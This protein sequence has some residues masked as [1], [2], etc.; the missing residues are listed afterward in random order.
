[1]FADALE[2]MV[3]VKEY[4]QFPVTVEVVTMPPLVQFAGVF[5]A[6]ELFWETRN[7]LLV[8]VKPPVTVY[9]TPW[10]AC[11]VCELTATEAAKET[12]DAR[13]IIRMGIRIFSGIDFRIDLV[14]LIS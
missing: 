10:T 8:A 5:D 6:A 7:P 11:V 2:F 4:C 13:E 3:T 9:M 1:V 12:T 14:M